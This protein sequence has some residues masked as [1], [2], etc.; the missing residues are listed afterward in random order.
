MKLRWSLSKVSAQPHTLQKKVTKKLFQSKIFKC[1]YKNR[2]WR[3]VSDIMWQSTTWC[4]C[5]KKNK[6]KPAFVNW[7]LAFSYPSDSSTGFAV[8]CYWLLRYSP[9]LWLNVVIALHYFTTMNWNFLFQPKKLKSYCNTSCAQTKALLLRKW[10][11]YIKRLCCVLDDMEYFAYL[12]ADH[13]QQS[14]TFYSRGPR[15]Q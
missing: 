3:T 10:D 12:H 4:R 7:S 11:T 15:G 13:Y 2:H 1:P 6:I 5:F 14:E 9:F 8:R